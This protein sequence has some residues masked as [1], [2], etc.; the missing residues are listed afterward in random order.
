MSGSP[1]NAVN[2]T[3]EENQE[4]VS[5]DEYDGE[6]NLVI[7]GLSQVDLKS[8]DN[9]PKHCMHAKK[10]TDGDWHFQLEHHSCILDQ[11]KKAFSLE[12]SVEL[13]KGD[14][15]IREFPKQ[16]F[17]LLSYGLTFG[18]M[19]IPQ[20][21]DIWKETEHSTK[22]NNNGKTL[23]G[24]FKFDELPKHLVQGVDRSS[25]AH[26]VWERVKLKYHSAGNLVMN[27]R[28]RAQNLYETEEELNNVKKGEKKLWKPCFDI[29]TEVQFRWS[30]KKSSCGHV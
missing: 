9:R 16:L 27:F 8:K 21:A 24:Q 25:Y 3:E 29:L 7:P 1:T 17:M 18:N 5:T 22:W 13:L 20:S 6:S 19:C 14:K 30:L 15:T 11:L 28:A 23:V 26:G 2:V 10:T 12:P 4:T